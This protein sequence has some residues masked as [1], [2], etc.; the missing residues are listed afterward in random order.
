MQEFLIPV[1]IPVVHNKIIL[2]L[3][4][5][6]TVSDELAATTQLN[7]KDMIQ[8]DLSKE[9]ITEGHCKWINLYGAPADRSGKFTDF[10]NNDP[11]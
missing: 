11:N 4:D 2:K 7:I 8:Y 5:Y 3:Y 1:E 6:D 10:M 9:N